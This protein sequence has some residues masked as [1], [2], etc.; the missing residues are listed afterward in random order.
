[1]I[2][3]IT[4]GGEECKGDPCSVAKEI[5][6]NGMVVRVDVVGFDVPP[7]ERKQLECVAKEGS[8]RYYDVKDKQSMYI[9]VQELRKD[10]TEAVNA[11]KKNPEPSPVET[12]PSPVK[13]S[14][15]PVP[16]LPPVMAP[17]PSTSTSP[18]PLKEE[19]IN[20][21]LQSEGG[22]VVKAENS[23]W[24]NTISGHDRKS[25]WTWTKQ[26]AVFSFKDKK[27]AKFSKFA[28]AIPGTLPQNVQEFELLAADSPEGPYRMLGHFMT[29]NMLK[30]D[31]YQEFI[32]NEVTAS[33]LK[34]KV[35][36]NYGYPIKGWGNTQIFQLR[37]FATP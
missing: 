35:I 4:D 17:S 9:A 26:E 6:L 30:R 11:K 18:S 8:G 37:L 21:L 24:E 32:F 25:V 12:P 19:R 10:V 3:L 14:P 13:P 28:I 31:M 33:Y 15:T 23:G 34:F 20:L 5:A 1:M 29:Q 7:K 22:E 16:T 27:P 36:S 2:V